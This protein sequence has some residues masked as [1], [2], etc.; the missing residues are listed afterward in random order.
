[1][2]IR[3]SRYGVLEQIQALTD[4]GLKKIKEKRVQDVL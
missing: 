1:M 4:K 2:F 3:E